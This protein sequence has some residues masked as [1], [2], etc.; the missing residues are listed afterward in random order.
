M[1]SA[2]N[3]DHESQ[4]Y[5]L[6]RLFATLEYV[7]YKALGQTNTTI[8]DRFFKSASTTPRGVFGNLIGNAQAHLSKIRNQE[9]D[10]AYN[11]A[12]K[13]IGSIMGRISEFP[14][15]LSPEKQA[16]FSL[17]Y[18]HQREERFGRSKDSN[19]AQSDGE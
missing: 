1:S 4:A 8:T 9:G 11:G 17:G 14:A 15:T 13:Q 16:L 12:Q 2:L 7:Q 3:P 18:Y 6:G 19:E 5:Q 10:K